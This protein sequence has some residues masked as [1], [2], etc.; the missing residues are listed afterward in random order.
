MMLP[1]TSFPNVNS[2]LAEDE[3]GNPYLVSKNYI[4]PGF[5]MTVVT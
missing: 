3:S 5:V 2:L 4:V 1:I